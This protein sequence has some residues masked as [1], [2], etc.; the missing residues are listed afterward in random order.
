MSTLHKWVLGGKYLAKHEENRMA[1]EGA[2]AE[3]RQR[4][5][6]QRFRN[7]DYL[8]RSRYEWM[9]DYLKPDSVIIEIGAGAGF[10]E[11]YLKYRPILTDAADHPWINRFIDATQMDL[12]DESVDVIIASHTVHHFYSPY[13]FFMECQRVLKKG[14]IVII[15][16]INTSFFMR[17]L[18]RMMRH[19]GWAY[20]VDVFNPNAIVN[21]ANDLWSANCAVP[22]LL[23]HNPRTFEHTFPKLQVTR[24]KCCEFL[25]FPLSGGVIAKT[26]IP[27]LP[28]IVL[29]SVMVVDSILT[30]I[31]PS[32]FALG[33]Q[34]VVQRSL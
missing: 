15:Q 13:K 14:G 6:Q 12:A 9:N 34:V 20:D 33:R 3:A 24:N 7:L 1:S 25:L 11:L 32:I 22:E 5:F 27:E 29:R 2:V 23:F 30:Q 28:E 17:L 31:A 18:L 21:D 26:S 10:S 16:E 19:E 8:L 4:F